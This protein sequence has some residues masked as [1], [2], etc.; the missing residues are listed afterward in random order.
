[1]GGGESTVRSTVNIQ[2]P[3]FNIQHPRGRMRLRRCGKEVAEMAKPKVV[4]EV[5]SQC[6]GIG[7]GEW[8]LNYRLRYKEWKEVGV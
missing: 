3:T 7:S 4:M 2:H 1:M 5:F 8:R 6:R